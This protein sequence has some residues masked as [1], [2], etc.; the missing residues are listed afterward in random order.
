MSE[1]ERQ[2]ELEAELEE[3]SDRAVEFLVDMIREQI[4]TEYSE[5]ADLMMN[6]GETLEGW[7]TE[8]ETRLSHILGK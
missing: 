8:I 3:E 2:E 6:V 4:V 1:E 5:R 7:Q